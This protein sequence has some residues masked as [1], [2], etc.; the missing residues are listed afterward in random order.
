[1]DVEMRSD[2][3]LFCF[4]VLCILLLVL[5]PSTING[6]ELFWIATLILYLLFRVIRRIVGDST[7]NADDNPRE[8]FW[9]N[10]AEVMVVVVVLGGFFVLAYINNRQR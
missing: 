7:A 8:S 9:L 10:L 6:R 3:T 4:I 5:F 1:M 2:I